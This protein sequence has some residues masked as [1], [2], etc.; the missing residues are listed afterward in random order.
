MKKKNNVTHNYAFVFYDIKEKRCHKVFKICKKYFS[1]HQLSVFR[2]IMTPSDLKE[3]ENEIKKVIVPHEDMVSII[4][5]LN[6]NSFKE[7]T[8]GTNV[9]TGENLFI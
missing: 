7:H 2:G 1:H 3:F 9:K 8:I 6:E 5:V 4:T